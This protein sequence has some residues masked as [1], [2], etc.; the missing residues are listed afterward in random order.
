MTYDKSTSHMLFRLEADKHG[1]PKN[2]LS[3]WDIVAEDDP[4][5]KR[6]GFCTRGLYF[7]E[8]Q[9]NTTSQMV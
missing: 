2:T 6:I 3:N 8:N 9:N 1:I 7:V 5:L 4:F